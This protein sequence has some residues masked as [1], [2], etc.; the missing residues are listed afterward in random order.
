MKK[1]IAILC[2]VLALSASSFSAMAYNDVPTNTMESTSIT[3][4]EGLGI[5]SA[6]DDDN[7][8]SEDYM[9]RGQFAVAAA[10]MMKLDVTEG[11]MPFLA[12]SAAEKP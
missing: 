7:F 4:A 11:K 9:T 10:K 6:K 3:L 5:M 1:K 2:L 12:A 8:G